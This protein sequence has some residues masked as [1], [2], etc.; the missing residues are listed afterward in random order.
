M[1]DLFFRVNLIVLSKYLLIE[2]SNLTQ[3]LMYI[4]VSLMPK[5]DRDILL[6]WKEYRFRF[7]EYREQNKVLKD[8]L[9]VNNLISMNLFQITHQQ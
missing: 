3:L 4:V 7:K 6:A 8:R 5:A 1:I 2:D 9:N